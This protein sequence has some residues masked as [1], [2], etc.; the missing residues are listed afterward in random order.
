MNATC[1]IVVSTFILDTIHLF[2]ILTKYYQFYKS[3]LLAFALC[4]RMQSRK[5][6][7]PVT[8]DRRSNSCRRR[9][10]KFI[11]WFAIFLRPICRPTNKSL[12][13]PEI[14]LPQ[15]GWLD[16]SETAVNDFCASEGQ[17]GGRFSS[18]DKNWS[19]SWIF[20]RWFAARI[21]RRG[22]STA[23]RELMREALKYSRAA[24]L[25]T[26]TYTAFFWIIK[27]PQ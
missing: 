27:Q 1:F 26:Q 23:L 13:S 21:S 5:K 15:V 3:L 8:L 11:C 4:C 16:C 9:R 17:F 19:P 7:F 10:I 18:N 24:F 22:P 20:H 2:M 12:S 6:F 14:K 25:N